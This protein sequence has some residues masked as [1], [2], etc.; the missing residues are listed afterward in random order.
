MELA[1]PVTNPIPSSMC[2]LRS[3]ISSKLR[4]MVDMDMFARRAYSPTD[5]PSSSATN[6]NACTQRVGSVP[7]SAKKGSKAPRRP[8]TADNSSSGRPRLDILNAPFLL[9]SR[10][11]RICDWYCTIGNCTGLGKTNNEAPGELLRSADCVRGPKV[12]GESAIGKNILI[13]SDGTG[14]ASGLTL[15]ERRTNVYKLYHSIALL[16]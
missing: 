6:K 4:D 2:R 9:S 11:S 5:N 16:T 13:F 10:L 8:L 14:Q 1:L 15:D 12:Y 7:L 3:P